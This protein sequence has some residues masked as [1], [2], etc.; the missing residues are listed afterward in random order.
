MAREE[1]EEDGDIVRMEIESKMGGETKEK[2]APAFFHLILFHVLHLYKTEDLK[3]K[4]IC[5]L[6]TNV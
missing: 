1:K 5:C 2:G 3:G 6:S 4:L